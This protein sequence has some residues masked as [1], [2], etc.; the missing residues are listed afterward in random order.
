MINMGGAPGWWVKGNVRLDNVLIRIMIPI[1][2]NRSLPF[3]Y[4]N[5]L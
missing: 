5:R 2:K 4:K 1:D 3:D